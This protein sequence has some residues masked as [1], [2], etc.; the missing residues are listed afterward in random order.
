MQT[1][2][3]YYSQTSGHRFRA[4]ND[5]QY[6]FAY[7]HYVV[8]NADIKSKVYDGKKFG[9]Y[10]PYLNFESALKNY[11]EPYFFFPFSQKYLWLCMNAGTSP[12]DP[13]YQKIRNQGISSDYT[14]SKLRTKSRGD[15]T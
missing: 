4:K 8:E 9:A 3:R 15:R 13:N 5:V 6:A 11:L 2:E 14:I 7:S 1:Y 12:Q 10:V